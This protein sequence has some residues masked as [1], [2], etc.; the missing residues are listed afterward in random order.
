VESKLTLRL[1]KEVINQA[2]SYAK[3]RNT[4]LSKLIENYLQTVTL[5]KTEKPAITPLVESL[6]GVIDMKDKDYGKDYTKFLSQK[7]S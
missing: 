1:N 5:K 6:T 7:H 3:D 4:S 2:K